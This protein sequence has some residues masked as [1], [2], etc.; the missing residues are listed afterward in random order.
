MLPVQ[1]LVLPRQQ[2]HLV[3]R[4]ERTALLVPRGEE[5][6]ERPPFHAGAT[7]A[8]QPA[9]SRPAT[10]RVAVSRVTDIALGELDDDLARA[11]GQRDIYALQAEWYNDGHQWDPAGRAWLVRIALDAAAAPRLLHRDSTHGY[12]SRVHDA[13]PDEPEAVDDVRLAAGR[14]HAE[15][16][17]RD[18]FEELLAQRRELPAPDRLRLAL[19]D[20]RARGIDVEADPDA[21]K[22]VLRIADLERKVYRPADRSPELA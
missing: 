10:C 22:I 12:T 4:G 6:G 19:D 9:P 15:K 18:R 2:I 3:V 14:R 5:A 20:A 11:L 8:L 17:E 1:P 7:I 21:R 13:L 16:T